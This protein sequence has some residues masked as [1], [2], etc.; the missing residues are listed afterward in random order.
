MLISI[1]KDFEALIN[2]ALKYNVSDI[3]IL[4]KGPRYLIQLRHHNHLQI[5]AR[6]PLQQGIF[7][8]NYC[9]FHSGMDISEHRRPQLGSNQFQE[10]CYLRYS[11]VGNYLSQESM[12]IRIIHKL[13]DVNLNFLMPQQIKQIERL[14]KLRGLILLAGPTGSGKTTTIYHLAKH[15]SQDQMVM[16]IEDPVE[17]HE[18]EFLQ[19]Q[20]NVKAGMT[21]QHLLEVGL[22]HRPDVFV[23][24]EIR[25][26]IT[27]K[28]AVQAS[29]SGHLVLST[30][31]AQSPEG[32]IE[33]LQQ[34]G[35]SNDYLKQALNL[36]L[37]QRLI[38]DQNHHLAALLNLVT[39][40][41]LWTHP[42]LEESWTA[43][44]ENLHELAE[45]NRIT[46]A[47]AKAF[48]FG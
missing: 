20:V 4:P 7:L 41:N 25:D 40:N 16:T 21:Y 28:A 45:K 36:V 35:I 30:V 15:L 31:H 6:W 12:V 22:R 32:I 19:L 39:N 44:R 37:Y 27:A 8:L 11:T 34:L 3:Y 23:I 10:K 48:R 1:K 24:G 46:T 17:I 33:R 9:K 13:Q 38:P 47:T 5:Y 26:E 18:P 29:L 42:K 14:T 43:W 2:E